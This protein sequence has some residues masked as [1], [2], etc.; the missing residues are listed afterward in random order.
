MFPFA[1]LTIASAFPTVS[2]AIKMPH[3]AHMI[4]YAEHIFRHFCYQQYVMEGGFTN[5]FEY[6]NMRVFIGIVNDEEI[7]LTSSVKAW[8]NDGNAITA[9]LGCCVQ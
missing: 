5:F 8:Q 7:Y 2:V 6:A 4:P 3:R 9:G 1:I